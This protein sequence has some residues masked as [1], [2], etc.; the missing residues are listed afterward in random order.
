MTL[1]ALIRKR[2]PERLATAIPAT[3]AT[4]GI[5][6]GG[7]VARIATVAVANPTEAK[8]AFR[9]W[10]V[11]YPDREPVQVACFPDATL[12][13]IM[14]RRPDAI[15]AEPIHQEPKPSRALSPDLERRIHAM[16]ERWSYTHDELA[17]VLESARR[18]SDGWRGIVESEEKD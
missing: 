7:T 15:A 10:L 14:E 17:S 12:A 11:H 6:S 9:W 13:E 8:T 3:F 5:V 1:S 2:E 16:A 18:D 4:H